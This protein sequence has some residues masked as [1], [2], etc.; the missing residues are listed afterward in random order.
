[1]FCVNCLVL[2]H[3]LM[4]LFNISNYVLYYESI[5]LPYNIF[6]FMNDEY[7]FNVTRHVK[8]MI[9]IKELSPVATYVCMIESYIH[10][11]MSPLYGFSHILL[12]VIATNSY[13][14]MRQQLNYILIINIVDK[15]KLIITICVNYKFTS[16]YCTDLYI[17]VCI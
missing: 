11:I 8:I 5:K 14:Q 2:L 13:H 9:I 12:L 15:K 7:I 16:Y 3:N 6:N 10:F 4:Y 17:K 1:M